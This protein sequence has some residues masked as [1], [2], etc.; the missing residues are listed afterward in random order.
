[1]RFF[2][3]VLVFLLIGFIQKSEAQQS[4]SG[5]LDGL[6]R[7]HTDWFQPVLA[8]PAAFEVQILYTRIDR[9]EKNR[10]TFT[11]FSWRE[12]PARYFYPAS[13]IKFP[14]ILLALEKINRLRIPGLTRETPMFHESSWKGQ[15]SVSEDSTSANGWPSVAHYSRKILL[16]SDNAAFNRL[17]DF[18]GPTEANRLLTSKGYRTRMRHRLSGSFTPAENRKTNA[19]VFK[20]GDSIIYR[21]PMLTTDSLPG[22][23][24]VL[25]GKGHFAGGKLVR[26]PM[27]F[28]GKNVMTLRD[29]HNMIRAVVFP[30]SMPAAKRFQL[31][32][33]DRRFLLQYMSQY[34]RES[35]YPAYYR[36]STL[37][38]NWVKYFLP[39]KADSTGSIRIFNKVGL[40]YGYVSDHSYFV[41]FSRNIEF[42][43][44]A[45]ILT[46]R[47]GIFNDNQ[48]EYDEIAF[49]FM[50]NLG[51]L[52]HEYE[53]RRPRKHVPDLTQ[54]RMIYDRPD[55]AP[56]P[57]RF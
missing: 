2:R 30:E 52:I 3:I 42:L 41:D 11:T 15:P 51:R 4:S 33:D 9:D 13:T 44:S 5:F 53:I 37:T 1:M 46:N 40:A 23:P 36:D 43:L 20:R 50:Q 21:Q 18:V 12:N 55:T 57:S 27:N 16:V 47:D 45:V 29:G 7:S 6:L 49:P 39:Q 19:V 22:G 54:F 26:K 35:P 8:N 10:P 24:P 34:P 25:R 31:T 32:E 56:D 38:D 28:A 17:Y 14:M 48:Y